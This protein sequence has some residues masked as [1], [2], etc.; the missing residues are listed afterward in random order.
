M[1]KSV[2]PCR[3][4]Q[5]LGFLCALLFGLFT[6]A[7]TAS[8]LLPPGFRP[9]PLGVHA[10]VGG[11]IVIKPGDIL[12]SGTVVIRDG[13]IEVGKD[14]TL[15]AADG[16]ILDARVNVKRMWL[17]GKEISLE[18]RHTRLYDRYRDRPRN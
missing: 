7:L 12:E 18:S 17:A 11:K 16:S 5:V 9:L 2:K 1:R 6:A 8:E 4:T 14:A 10:L 3:R 13:F 15:F